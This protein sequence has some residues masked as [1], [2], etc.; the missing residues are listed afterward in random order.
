MIA[1]LF[2]CLSTHFS[3]INQYKPC[4][5]QA[6]ELHSNKPNVPVLCATYGAFRVV[7]MHLKHQFIGPLPGLY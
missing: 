2:S 4:Q 7:C 5:S 3:T 6:A 1:Q